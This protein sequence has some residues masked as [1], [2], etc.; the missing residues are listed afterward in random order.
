MTPQERI[1]HVRH[2]LALKQGWD[3][4]REGEA[5]PS[6]PEASQK[7]FERRAGHAVGKY[8]EKHP[9]R[10]RHTAAPS[11]DRECWAILMEYLLRKRPKAHLHLIDHI[12]ESAF[13]SASKA[14]EG[15]VTGGIGVPPRSRRIPLTR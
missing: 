13:L 6:L 12:F 11:S 4:W 5:M 15:R 1:E 10:F 7:Y 8:V 3:R 2:W 9:D 14:L